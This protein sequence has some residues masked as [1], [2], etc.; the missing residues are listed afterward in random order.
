MKSYDVHQAEITM[1]KF[2]KML[3]EW[4]SKVDGIELFEAITSKKYFQTHKPLIVKIGGL[5]V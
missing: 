1:E 4:T 3:N 2:T 5:C